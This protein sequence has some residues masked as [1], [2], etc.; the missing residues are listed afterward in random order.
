MAVFF[1][2]TTDNITPPV[3][4]YSGN[5]PISTSWFRRVNT[6][7][8]DSSWLWGWAWGADNTVSVV[9]RSPPVS[10]VSRPASFGRMIEDAVN[11]YGIPMNAFTMSCDEEE[12]DKIPIWNLEPN[13]GCPKL[14]PSGNHMP[15][16]EESWIA[17]V[18]RGNC[19]FVAK[20]R[21]AQRFGAKA[22]IVGG[23]DPAVTG[24]PDVLVNMYSQSDSSDVKIPSTYIK[25]S[26]YSRL[27]NLIASSNTSTSG[28]KTVSL[29]ITADYASWEWYSPILTFIVL[30][31][32]PS[33]LTLTTLLIHRIRAAR[34][35]QR[36]RAPEDVVNRL[37]WRVWTGSGWEKH[38]GP[39]PSAKLSAD[40]D[41][42]CGGDL[43]TILELAGQQG[44]C[45]PSTSRDDEGA[46]TESVN[47]PWFDAQTECAI[48]L[49]DFAKGDRVR[50]LPCKHI[51]H[52]DEVDEWLIHRKKLCPVCKAD[53]TQPSHPYH[54]LEPLPTEPVNSEPASPST[55]NERTPLLAQQRLLP[56]I[57]HPDTSPTRMST[58]APSHP[59]PPLH[60]DDERP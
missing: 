25:F 9:D 23:D 60:R 34:A 24:N 43:D 35:E 55:S 15:E 38:E 17:I 39:V 46:E 30:L 58:S 49:N 32:L 29:Q 40:T 2:A 7:S 36:E 51:F 59:L 19:S 21:E 18:Q 54:H 13:L 11:G 53:V 37:P 20:V 28:I 47:P 41:L 27:S 50:V 33:A 12:N 14:C 16:P 8:A 1:T 42:E 6:A 48:C 44:Q 22:V 5:S 4:A 31:L 10:F 57:G 56:L 3:Y 26:D 52:L 45:P